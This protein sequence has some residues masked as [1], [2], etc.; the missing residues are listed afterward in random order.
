VPTTEAKRNTVSSTFFSEGYQNHQ[1]QPAQ[2]HVKWPEFAQWCRSK[3]GV[4]HVDG[5]CKWLNGQKLQWRDKVRT[6]VDEEGYVLNGK[7][8]THV[9]AIQMGTQNPELLTRFRRAVKRDGKIHT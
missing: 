9:Q 3:G 1:D 8:F 7:F 6:N 5:F 2:N 4:P